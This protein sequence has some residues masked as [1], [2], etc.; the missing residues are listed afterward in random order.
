MESMLTPIK[1][2]KSRAWQR[3]KKR[4]IFSSMRLLNPWPDA[5]KRSFH[6]VTTFLV[7]RITLWLRQHVVPILNNNKKNKQKNIS[8]GLLSSEME[9]NDRG[10]LQVNYS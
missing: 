10:D 7:R 9:K 2:A 4:D 5:T 8:A 1:R 6:T 3:T